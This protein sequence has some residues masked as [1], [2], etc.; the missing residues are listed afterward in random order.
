MKNAAASFTHMKTYLR[1]HRS[2]KTGL[3]L[4]YVTRVNVG[5]PS[6]DLRMLLKTRQRMAIRTAP[7]S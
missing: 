5:D 2:R 1:T 6:T 7:M 4:D 3:P